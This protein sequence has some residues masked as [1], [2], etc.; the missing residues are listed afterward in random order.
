M[1][2]DEKYNPKHNLSKDGLVLQKAEV[3][4][5]RTGMKMKQS[6][7]SSMSTQRTGGRITTAQTNQTAS[8]VGSK[9]GRT[10]A[11]IIAEFFCSQ[12]WN[13]FAQKAIMLKREREGTGECIAKY[14]RFKKGLR[15]FWQVYKTWIVRVKQ[16]RAQLKVEEE[17]KMK[18]LEEEEKRLEEEQIQKKQRPDEVMQIQEVNKWEFILNE[19]DAIFSIDEDVDLS[20]FGTKNDTNF[21]DY[22]QKLKEI[23][24]DKKK[25]KKEIKN[26]KLDEI[27]EEVDE[28]IILSPFHQK[29]GKVLVEKIENAWE[30]KKQRRE[31]KKLRELLKNLPP[32]CRTSYVKLMQL[33]RETADLQNDV[34]KMPPRLF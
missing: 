16:Q 33:R 8:R 22:D 29:A 10:R 17:Q 4:F 15:K 20:K 31:G 2:N 7:D 26:N 14:R 3:K 34:T 6:T 21:D 28:S 25:I 19:D 32:Q 5:N 27:P 30:K 18:M 9:H 11:Q 13:Y 23:K 12:N 1:P 24:E